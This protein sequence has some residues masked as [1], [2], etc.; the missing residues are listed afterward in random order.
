MLDAV[1][2]GKAGQAP[3]PRTRDHLSG[4]YLERQRRRRAGPLVAVEAGIGR[5]R[6]PVARHQ[7]VPAGQ[8]EK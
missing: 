5:G 4:A 3:P 7:V 6:D 1:G 8:R 2:I